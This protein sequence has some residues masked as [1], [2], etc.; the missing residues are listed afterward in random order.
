MAS[1]NRLLIINR[2]EIAVRI[3]RAAKELGITTVAAYSDADEQSL[4]VRLADES[5]NIGAAHARKSYLNH[6]AV[7]AAAQEC[8]VDAVHPG[9]GFLSENAEFARTV[10]DAG[11][12]WVGPDAE[13]IA[14]MGHKAEA[15]QTARAA[16]V[17]VVPGSQ[18]LIATVEDGVAAAETIGFPVLIKAAAGGGGRGIRIA[19]DE[20]ELVDGIAS[21]QQEAEA[22]F[23]DGGVYLERFIPHARHIEVQVL[24]DGVDAVHFYERDCSLQRRRQKIWEEAPAAILDGETRNH[25]CESAV[26]L[27]RSVGYCGAGT[28]EYLFDPHTGEYFFIEMNT[29][30]QV[31]HP[32]TEEICGVDLI[33]AMIRVA[34]GEPLP[35]RQEDIRP[36]GHAIEVRINA[37]DPD[38]NFMPGPG[39]IADLHWPA[40][41]GVRID[42]MAYAGYQI[43]PYYDSMIGKLIVWAEDRDG[44]L[45]RLDRALSEL[46]LTGLKTTLPFFERLLTQDDVRNNAFH[47]T[48]IEQLLEARIS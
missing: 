21:A 47:T 17:P 35:Y 1:I 46:E 24:G 41:P 16:G 8:K 9:Y 10:A 38:R 42:S 12:I 2:G 34:Q 6:D 39:T 19:T 44:A 3:I 31:E 7:L 40:G 20:S 13:T 48:W 28:V 32:I 5:V 4:A 18:G 25:L 43:P 30:I 15:I 23:G 37:E 26:E 14:R 27:A 33:Q 36:R 29:R 45:A 11:L 22:A